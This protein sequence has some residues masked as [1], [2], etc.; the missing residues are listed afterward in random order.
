VTRRGDG[1]IIDGI[2]EES[3]LCLWTMVLGVVGVV[4]GRIKIQRD[5]R[6]WQSFMFG[7][8]KANEPLLSY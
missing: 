1:A 2:L 4:G 7:Q 3:G 5:E 6:T 8:R